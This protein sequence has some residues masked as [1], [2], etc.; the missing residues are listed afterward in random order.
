MKK[1]RFQNR[2]RYQKVYLS[3]KDVIIPRLTDTIS[4]TDTLEPFFDSKTI[5]MITRVVKNLSKN[6]QRVSNLL[7]QIF[8]SLKC[9]GGRGE[10]QEDLEWMCRGWYE[11]A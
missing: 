7:Y 9:G 6:E 3:I 2:R 5:A 1:W 10:E 11:G 4:T 8:L